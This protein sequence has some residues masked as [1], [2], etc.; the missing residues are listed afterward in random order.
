MCKNVAHVDCTPCASVRRIS[1]EELESGKEL[2]RSLA[3]V[4]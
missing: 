4:R 2:E 3:N 1:G